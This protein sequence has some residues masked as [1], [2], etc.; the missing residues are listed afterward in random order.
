MQAIRPLESTVKPLAYLQAHNLPVTLEN[1]VAAFVARP[2]DAC[3][4]HE[5][6]I[7]PEDGLLICPC[8]ALARAKSARLAQQPRTNLSGVR[9]PGSTSAATTNAWNERAKYSPVG[10]KRASQ[11]RRKSS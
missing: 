8:V 10:C 3:G 4:G 7:D 6:L 11:S 9:P 1:R 5:W 2:C